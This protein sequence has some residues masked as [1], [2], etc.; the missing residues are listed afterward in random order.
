MSKLRSQ[1]LV[2]AREPLA[3]RL[4]IRRIPK[5]PLQRGPHLR[6]INPCVDPVPPPDYP[7][8]PDY[9]TWHPTNVLFEYYRQR[10]FHAPKHLH[11][12][13]RSLCQA[14]DAENH[15]GSRQLL[16]KAHNHRVNWLERYCATWA[17]RRRK[18]AKIK[19]AA[20]K[21]EAPVRRSSVLENDNGFEA[22]NRAL[23]ASLG[24]FNR[25]VKENV[26]PS[27]GED[28]SQDEEVCKTIE[29]ELLDDMEEREEM[30]QDSKMTNETKDGMRVTEADVQRRISTFGPMLRAR[31][32]RQE[33]LEHELKHAAMTE[34][35][36]AIFGRVV[37][38]GTNPG[39][40]RTTGGPATGSLKTLREDSGSKSSG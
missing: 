25:P 22:K 18:R 27:V 28:E 35:T 14:F 8:V 21:R 30:A 38:Q 4:P 37:C 24:L 12:H 3:S 29:D 33:K 23:N 40:P 31:R 6:L 13:F 10:G 15:A 1:L 20:M 26:K 19:R 7:F 9:D 5:A 2:L 17:E 11:D 36:I 39:G 34:R 32:A 16:K